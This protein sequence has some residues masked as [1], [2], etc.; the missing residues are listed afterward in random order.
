MGLRTFNA[1]GYK[2]WSLIGAR[3]ISTIPYTVLS[4]KRTIY[5][6]TAFFIN[7]ATVGSIILLPRDITKLII[8]QFSIQDDLVSITT[9]GI[10]QYYECVVGTLGF[11]EK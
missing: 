8:V 6:G 3:P 1:Q 10:G 9:L 11:E 4:S 5:A 7:D 2:D